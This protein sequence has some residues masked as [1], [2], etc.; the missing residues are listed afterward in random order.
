MSPP[1]F[2]A[3]ANLCRKIYVENKVSVSFHRWPIVCLAINDMGLSL[4]FVIDSY[5]T[6]TSGNTLT[7]GTVGCYVSS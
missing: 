2:V 3:M 7:D 4:K 1:S 6:L 5:S